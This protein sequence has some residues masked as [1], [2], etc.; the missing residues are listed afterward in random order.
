MNKIAIICILLLVLTL[1][2]IVI[3]PQS[4]FGIE[5]FQSPQKKI[6]LYQSYL[7][8]IPKKFVDQ[9]I[10]NIPL[11]V[12]YQFYDN[13]RITE[14]MKK[15]DKKVYDLFT[16]LKR[17]AHKIDLWRYCILYENGGM[18]MDADSLLINKLDL[19]YFSECDYF[20]IYDNM[21]DN[22]HNGF[23]IT[24]P[25]N[26]LFKHMIDWMVEKGPDIKDCYHCPEYHYN[27]VELLKHANQINNA[28]F[29]E[30]QTSRKTDFV[31]KYGKK[32]YLI[33]NRSVKYF[34][35]KNNIPFIENHNPSYPF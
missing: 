28:D 16:N 14:Y 20:L 19:K 21:Y 6:T 25:K 31:D 22:I 35:D 26:P 4:R 24:Y 7:K 13:K 12:D 9:N 30:S 23:L 27:L 11:E 32:M 18:Y 10:K 1:S 17:W 34:H 29:K 2:T 3:H 5:Q 8:P 15:Q 33:Y